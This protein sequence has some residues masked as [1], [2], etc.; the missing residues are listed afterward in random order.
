MRK[1]RGSA[2]TCVG[3]F[4]RLVLSIKIGTAHNAAMIPV[5]GAKTADAGTQPLGYA[6]CT[7][8]PSNTSACVARLPLAA[9]ALGPTPAVSDA[10]PVGGRAPHPPTHG[11]RLLGAITA[12]VRSRILAVLIIPAAEATLR[13]A[14]ALE[15]S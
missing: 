3:Y 14:G 5:T 1:A 2:H 11:A 13:A 15:P 10:A 7:A 8:P 6:F 4:L 9:P 12:M